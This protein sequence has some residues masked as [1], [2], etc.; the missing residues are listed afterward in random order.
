MFCCRSR[1]YCSRVLCYMSLL[2]VSSVTQPRFLLQ[3][4]CIG[5]LHR[6]HLYGS[7]RF[8]RKCGD[9]QT[10]TYTRISLLYGSLF[11]RS[12]GSVCRSSVSVSHV[13]ALRNSGA[14]SLANIWMSHATHMN[15]YITHMNKRG[16]TH[17][18]SER[19]LFLWIA[20]VGCSLSR[21]AVLWHTATHC[22]SRLGVLRIRASLQHTTTHCNTL[23]H[24]ATH[25]DTL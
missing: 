24:T 22:L 7:N 9:V 21:P 19:T 15:G 23:Q 5:V 25:Y 11:S 12:R 13:G 1:V 20:I 4:S 6:S 2:W 16:R 8:S 3:V 10:Y 14:V 17:C 18:S